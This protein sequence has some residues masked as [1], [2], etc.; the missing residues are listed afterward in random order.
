MSNKW[1]WEAHLLGW[2]DGPTWTLQRKFNQKWPVAA[3]EFWANSKG[4][5]RLVRDDTLIGGYF[6]N[7]LT[8]DSV[9]LVPAGFDLELL[10]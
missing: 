1:K 7:P 9:H 5:T 3:F 2:K 10:I 6:I 4:Y 8:G